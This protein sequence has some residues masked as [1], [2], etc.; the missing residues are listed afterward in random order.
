MSPAIADTVR[1]TTTALPQTVVSPLITSASSDPFEIIIELSGLNYKRAL[2]KS[3][4][5][6]AYHKTSNSTGRRKTVNRLNLSAFIY[7]VNKIF[8]EEITNG[9]F[10]PNG[11]AN[12]IET[13]FSA[14]ERLS[15]AHRRHGQLKERHPLD[16]EMQDACD[17]AYEL[18]SELFKPS[19][20]RNRELLKFHSPD[21]DDFLR[22]ISQ[23]TDQT[24]IQAIAKEKIAKAKVALGQDL[25][26]Q[27]R[28]NSADAIKNK[29]RI[30][31]AL[32]LVNLFTGMKPLYL[33]YFNLSVE[34]DPPP[35][36]TREI[37]LTDSATVA[38]LS[39]APFVQKLLFT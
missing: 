31:L 18:L 6:L 33:R 39:T 2:F 26:T 38:R 34:E 4:I 15:D 20:N 37:K 14:L 11:Y 17:R 13:I 12:R 35:E 22:L 29:H 16:P 19:F 28:I 5:D 9:I 23:H 30:L 27:A 32:E 10:N 25:I 36:A 7:A 1:N 24:D 3:Q 8:H 21:E